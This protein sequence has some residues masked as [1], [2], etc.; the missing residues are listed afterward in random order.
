MKKTFA[1][2]IA[3]GFLGLAS[4]PAHA[5]PDG[6]AIFKKKCAMCHAIDR[7]KTGPAVKDMNKDAAVLKDV[8]TNG[9]AKTMMKGFDKKLSAEEID[10]VVAFLVSQQK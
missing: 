9:R 6:A 2:L 4:Q 7:K 3:A 5:T 8:V 10:A 1:I